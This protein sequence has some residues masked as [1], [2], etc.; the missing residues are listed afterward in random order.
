MYMCL[1]NFCERLELR[2]QL[3]K[4]NGLLVRLELLYTNRPTFH[5]SIIICT[6]LVI[7]SISAIHVIINVI[8]LSTLLDS[9]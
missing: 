8:I 7:I 1:S 9:R 2:I 5:A 4:S 6:D 3:D